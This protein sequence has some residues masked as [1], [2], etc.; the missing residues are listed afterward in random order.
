[1]ASIEDPPLEISAAD[2]RHCHQYYA[3]MEA[4][5]HHSQHQEGLAQA[6]LAEYPSDEEV[7][8]PMEWLTD[9]ALCNEAAERFV[10]ATEY[11]TE[12]TGSDMSQ[13]RVQRSSRRFFT[14]KTF[15]RLLRF[16][17]VGFLLSWY[18]RGRS[19][20]DLLPVAFSW[21]KKNPGPR[22]VCLHWDR[23]DFCVY[24]ATY[25]LAY[26][27]PG[28]EPGSTEYSRQCAG[29]HGRSEFEKATDDGGILFRCVRDSKDGGGRNI[30]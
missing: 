23:Q 19:L 5:G 1:M 15:M 4:S 2:I 10:H 11:L 9:D 12:T 14:M 28:E 3:F 22:T 8:F 16:F 21:G 30:C 27:K 17:L 6:F 24:W 25:D 20:S 13:V 7:D 29:N 26:L 18:A